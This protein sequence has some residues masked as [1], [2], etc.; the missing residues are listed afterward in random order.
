M[1]TIL[2][3]NGIISTEIA[4]ALPAFTSSIRLVS[5]HPKKVNST[6]EI[7]SA[8]LLNASQTME[9]V[10]GS[11]IVYLA[12]GLPYN[13]KVWQ[14]QWPV[15]MQNVIN[16]CKEHQAKLVFFDNVYMYGPVAGTMSEE[17]PYNAT[18]KKGIT[19]AQIANML[20]EAMKDGSLSGMIC[21]A[22]EFYGPRNTLSGVNAMVFDNI[23]KG[24]K[25]QWLIND[26]V[27]RT[28]IYTP[29][30]GKATALLGNTPAAYG[31][32]WHLP[33][34]D[35]PV[36]GKEF[37]A[38]TSELYGKPLRYSVLNTFMVKLAGLFIPFVKETVELL[39]QYEQ[40]YK[41]SSDKFKKQF[42]DFQVTSYRQGITEIIA[43]IKHS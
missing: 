11:D 4:K 22:P 23:R 42:P 34:T 1:Q 24:K 17:T 29:D 41:F 25:L 31:Q 8:D 36:N 37:I 40:D 38:L 16:A 2:G 32:T 10:K 27:K 6:D 14:Q 28:Y 12:A 5:R 35:E 7:V 9:A 19:R 13:R 30:A 33:C 20:L 3:A 15:V 21:R 39:Y 26:Q 18:S 43:E